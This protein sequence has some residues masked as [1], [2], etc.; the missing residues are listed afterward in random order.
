MTA[1]SRSS[2]PILWGQVCGLATVQGAIALTWVIYNLYLVELLTRLGFPQGLATGLLVIENLLAMV[3]EPLMG[4]FSDQMQHRVGT[5][6]PLVSLG[7]IAAAACFIL[8]PTVLF[9]GQG[10]LLRWALP[11]L[12]VAWALAMTVFRSPALSLL[13]RYAFRTQLP[14]AASILTLVGGLAGAMG[15][16][17]NQFI[18]GLGPMVAFAIGS[19]VLLVAMV[20]L[21]WAGPNESVATVDQTAPAAQTAQTVGL[22][23]D[24]SQSSSRTLP[25]VSLALVFGAGVGVALG[26]RLVMGVFPAVIK[27]QVPDGNLPLIMGAIFIT[28]ALT[29]IPA[30]ALATRLGNRR[31]MVAGLAAMAFVA[32]A[33]MAIQSMVLGLLLAM[34]FGGAFSLVSNGTIPFALSMVPPDKAGLGTGIYFSGG[35]L[36]ASLAG[37]VLGGNAPTLGWGSS[38]GALAFLLAGVC[39]ASAGSRGAIAAIAVHSQP[40][41]RDNI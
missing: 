7:I 25:W 1:E 11:L 41:G 34:L 19:G 17:A 35:A 4:T 5:R 10:P 16:L 32:V 39:V 40:E 33:A 24:P 8:L 13:G 15:P 23:S 6:F 12:L 20:A 29:A 36:A 21:R 38:V 22:S 9:W 37:A 18:L 30:G 26:F 27:A 28:L 3:M 2:S 31:A 14:Q